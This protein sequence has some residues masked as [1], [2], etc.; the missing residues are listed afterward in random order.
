MTA[1][2][3][4][5][6]GAVG[7]AALVGGAAPAAA[8]Y[9]YGYSQPGNVIGQVINSVLNPYGNRYS[10]PYARPYAQP[11]GYG[12]GY[13]NPQLAAQQCSTAVQ[14]RIAYQ[15]RGG[16]SGYGYAN[17]AY[18]SARVLGITR[19]EPRSSTVTRVR[20]TATSG[21]NY[22]PYGV[23]A[24][25]AA[26]YGYASA[27]DLTFRCDIDYRGYVRDIDIDRR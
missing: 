5:G 19:I 6:I 1:L 26:G 10:Q 15:Y 13:M 12:T 17:N 18:S 14:Q 25:G 22:G 7:I 9:P 8:Q 21:T 16:Y 27:P 3:T 11:Y 23:G 24:Y 4:L 2:K 20:G